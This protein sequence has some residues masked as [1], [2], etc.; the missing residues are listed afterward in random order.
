ME[1]LSSKH[2]HTSANIS[3]NSDSEGAQSSRNS[4][5]K[6]KKKD[7]DKVYNIYI[8]FFGFLLF[9]LNCSLR[10]NIKP[11]NPKTKKKRNQAK[12]KKDI[13]KD[14]VKKILHTE[15]SWRSF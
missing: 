13:R 7:K 12:A 15:M 10:K 14:H 8:I 6:E 2:S 5:K 9:V 4:L 11:R 1:L 3:A